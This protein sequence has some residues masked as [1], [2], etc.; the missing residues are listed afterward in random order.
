MVRLCHS[1][2]LLQVAS[3]LLSKT[4]LRL[5]QHNTTWQSNNNETLMRYE[6]SN[7]ILKCLRH[8]VGQDVFSYASSVKIQYSVRLKQINFSVTDSNKS[9]AVSVR[10]GSGSL[11][12]TFAL[13][14]TSNK[15]NLSAPALS[16]CNPNQ[17]ALTEGEFQI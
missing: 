10:F 14:T 4:L 6:L 9:T 12:S 8:T 3:S 17:R 13:V 5:H 11:S 16:S 7:Y 1:P 15:H 2:C